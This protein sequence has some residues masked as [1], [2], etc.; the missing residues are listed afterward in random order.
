[1]ARA[2]YDEALGHYR[3]AVSLIPTQS[4]MVGASQAALMAGDVP[5]ALDFLKRLEPAS[6]RPDDDPWW[7]Y[8]TGAGRDVNPLMIH[9]WARVKSP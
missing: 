9:L 2:R 5:T 6:Q 3:E 8:H 4:P 7:D 1:V